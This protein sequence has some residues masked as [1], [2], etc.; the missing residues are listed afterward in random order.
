MLGSSSS[1]GRSRA[2]APVAAAGREGRPE[3]EADPEGRPTGTADPEGRPDGTALQEGRPEVADTAGAL[4]PAGGLSV[5]SVLIGS[6]PRFVRD[7]LGPLLA[8][9]VGWKLGGVVLGVGVATVF[10]ALAWAYERRQERP[11]MVARLSLA[12][13]VIHALIGLGTRSATIYLAQPLLV[14]AALGAAFTVSTLLSRPLA[15]VFAVELFPFTPEMQS[16]EDYRQVFGRLSLAWGAYL[17]IHAAVLLVVLITWGVDVF[18]VVNISTGAPIIAA[19]LTWSIWYAVARFRES[20][21]WGWA[22]RET[23]AGS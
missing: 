16:S 17:L 21:E 23:A 22:L 3:D 6:G 12:L 14:G 7:I 13:V 18:V 15:G 1:A 11:G 2:S 9:Y 4:F 20:E 5:R 10:A 19:L 8:F